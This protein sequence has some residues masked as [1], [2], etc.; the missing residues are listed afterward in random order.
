M[1]PD[2]SKKVKALFTVEDI[3]YPFPGYPVATGTLKVTIPHSRRKRLWHNRRIVLYDDGEALEPVALVSLTFAVIPNELV[4]DLV[5]KHTTHLGLTPYEPPHLKYKKTL[6]RYRLRMDLLTERKEAIRKGDVVQLGISVRN[7][8]DGTMSFGIDLFALRLVCLN[9]L[10]APS[11]LFSY[12]V[13]HV[14]E[15]Q[16]ILSE[17]QREVS[18]VLQKADA[19]IRIYR[20][21]ASTPLDETLARRLLSLNLPHMYYAPLPFAFNDKGEFVGL[22]ETI[23]VW[24]AFNR[25]TQVITHESRAHPLNRSLLTQRLHHILQGAT[26]ST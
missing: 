15:A 24:E 4:K 12:T 25:M 3:R 17:F 2:K 20:E 7:S 11:T 22:T 8:I 10:I 6:D 26:S 5:Q 14:G 9:G 23:D 1:K 21:M 19:L 16:M 13:R 18:E